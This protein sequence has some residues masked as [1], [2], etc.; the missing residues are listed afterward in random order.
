MLCTFAGWFQESEGGCV[1]H[2]QPDVRRKCGSGWLLPGA[3]L[4]DTTVLT[5]QRQRSKDNSCHPRCT[6]QHLGCMYLMHFLH[7]CFHLPASEWQNP[8]FHWPTKTVTVGERQYTYRK[9]Y[10]QAFPDSLSRTVFLL[11]ESYA[12]IIS[13]WKFGAF[14]DPKDQLLNFSCIGCSKTFHQKLIVYFISRFN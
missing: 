6:L 11:W 8:F 5:A 14:D 7:F 13:S 4:P 9:L 2:H 1:G 10:P 12:I 3:K